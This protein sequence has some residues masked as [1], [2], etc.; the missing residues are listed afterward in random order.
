MPPRPDAIAAT[1][2]SSGIQTDAGG[3]VSASPSVSPA[4][5]MSEYRT[6]PSGTC[7]NT[8]VRGACGLWASAATKAGKDDS[9]AR[10]TTRSTPMTKTA[11][12][13]TGTRRAPKAMNAVT[14]C[15]TVKLVPTKRTRSPSAATAAAA[16]SA[17]P[18][19]KVAGPGQGRVSPA[20][21]GGVT[22]TTLWMS[23]IS[24]PSP[25]SA[26]SAAVT[27]MRST[28]SR[29][30]RPAAIRSTDSQM[31]VIPGPPG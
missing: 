4:P 22:S 1:M 16:T 21:P 25:A 23:P 27:R 3:C 18:M 31:G 8:R 30:S 2:P 24:S 5:L 14:G 17:R 19:T 7:S 9:G 6:G 26:P 28:R 12:L 20:A 29:A 10:R 11:A 15:P 13:T